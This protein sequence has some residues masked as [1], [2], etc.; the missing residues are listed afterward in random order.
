MKK[1]IA[2]LFIISLIFSFDSFAQRNKTVTD[3]TAQLIKNE[4]MNS[5]EVMELAGYLTDV[6]GPRL[7]FSNEYKRAADWA[8]SKMKEWG[9]ENIH[10]E[11]YGPAGKGWTLKSFYAEVIEPLTFPLIAYPEAWSP[12]LNGTVKGDVVWLNADSEK[13]FESYKGKLKGKFVM[14]SAA[15]DLHPHFTPD[16]EKLNDSTLLKLA[17]AFQQERGRRF[18][19]PRMTMANFDSVF[20]LFKQFR[21]GIDSAAVANFIIERSFGPKKLQFCIDEGAEAVLSNSGG[22]DGTVFVQQAAVPQKDEDQG[23]R[24]LSVYDPDAPKIIPQIAV[25]AENY[26]RMIRMIEKGEKLTLQME[27]KTEITK[28]DSA[29]N[30]IAEIP[31]TDK[32]DEVVLIGGHFDSWHGGTGATDNACGSAVCMEALRILKRLNLTPRR[33]IRIGLWAG[34][35]EG[36][37]GSRAYVDKHFGEKSADYNSDA[38][39]DEFTM[40]QETKE[41]FNNFSVYFN[42]DNGAGRFRGIYLQ[43]NE[44]AGSVFRKWLHEF[45]DPGAQTVSISN[46]GGTDHLSFDNAGLP[47]FQFIQDPLDYDSRTHHSNMDVYDRLQKDDLEQAAEM[48]A[49]FAYKAAMMENKFPRKEKEK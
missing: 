10:F 24:R 39:A 23:T 6:Y 38:S 22:D 30:I 47:G 4:E 3:S 26:N 8:E 18:R 12:S 25:S 21:P 7:T 17:D 44:S 37:L 40:N 16:A 28:P 1:I 31:G 20:T 19:F 42:D 48:M 33:T 41:E 13:D 35:E 45:N 9:L 32:K 29:F 14:L 27:L 2:L 34:E 11:K 5:S 36:L 43:G 46:T 49:F 15:A